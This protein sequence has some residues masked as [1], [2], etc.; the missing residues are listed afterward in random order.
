[1]AKVDAHRLVVLASWVL[2]TVFF[3]GLLWLIWDRPPLPSWKGEEVD[4]SSPRD[5][6]LARTIYVFGV[7]S[8]FYVSSAELEYPELPYNPIIAAPVFWLV[9]TVL[10]FVI[11]MF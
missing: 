10:Y 7:A 1:M 2:G 5:L 9:V 6:W 4:L 3:A 11:V 8:A